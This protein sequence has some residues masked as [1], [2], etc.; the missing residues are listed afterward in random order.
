MLLRMIWKSAFDKVMIMM[1][2]GQN[3]VLTILSHFAVAFSRNNNSI[4][5][6]TN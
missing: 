6:L 4:V 5:E 2:L 1:K 3:V